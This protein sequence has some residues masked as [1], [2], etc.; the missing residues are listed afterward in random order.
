MTD[1]LDGATL[2]ASVSITLVIESDTPTQ[3]TIAGFVLRYRLFRERFDDHAP[4]RVLDFGGEQLMTRTVTID[5]PRGAAL[6]SATLRMMGPFDEQPG[7]DAES[8]GDTEDSTEAPVQASDLGVGV[9]AGESAATRTPLGQ[10]ALIQGATV[11]LV[12]L[13][14][15]SAARVR[16]HN[17]EDGQPG[18]ALCDRRSRADARGRPSVVRA[19][20]SEPAV[21]GAGPMWVVVQC[22]TGAL[23]WLTARAERRDRGSPGAATRCR[24]CGVDGRQ[25]R[26]RPRRRGV[27]RHAIR[28]ARCRRRCGSRISWRAAA[29]WRHAAAWRLAAIGLSRRTGNPASASGRRSGRSC[30]PAAAGTLSPVS[31]SL[32]SERARS[33][34]RVPPAF[35]FDP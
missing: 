29:P 15:A 8:E 24:R 14:D 10:A 27:V 22:E 18:E 23:V 35:E 6:W 33:R 17:D 21:V 34:H 5:V 26:G 12:A 1:S 2:P 13:A 28:R 16:L 11:D 19:D 25:C 32:V 3:A 7:D 4:K 30:S 9:A 20:F 31:L